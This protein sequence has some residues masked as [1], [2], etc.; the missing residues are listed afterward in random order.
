M[1]GRRSMVRIAIFKWIEMKKKW[2]EKK[3]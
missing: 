3:K 1:R 2:D